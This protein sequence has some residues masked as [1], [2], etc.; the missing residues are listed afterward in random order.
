[1]PPVKL[2][3]NPANATGEC[4]WGV[5]VVDRLKNFNM[6]ASATTLVI[7]VNDINNSESSFSN[8]IPRFQFNRLYVLEVDVI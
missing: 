4:G 3:I 7:V 6:A 5:G 8:V 2:Q 1:M